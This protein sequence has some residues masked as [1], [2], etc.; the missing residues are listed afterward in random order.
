[1]P[2]NSQPVI[3]LVEPQLDENVGMCARAMLN[4]GLRRLRLVAPREGGFGERARATAADADAVLD[5]AEVFATVDAA[6]ADCHRVYATTVRERALD[7]PVTDAETAAAGI[8]EAGVEGRE[9]AI[10]FG[11]EASGLDN[12]AVSRADVLLTFPTN[13]E[14]P[15]LNLAQAVLLFGWEWRRA[16]R[17]IGDAVEPES[18]ATG[19]ATRGELEG[20]LQRVE[21]ELDD[22]GFFL[23]PDLK[24]HGRRTLRGLFSKSR[25]TGRELKFLHGMLSALVRRDA[26][27]PARGGGDERGRQ[28]RVGDSTGLAGESDSI[29]RTETRKKG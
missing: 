6:V 10:L 19:W 29:D 13:P 12:E 28:G 15:S 18:E 2:I 26:N 3:V 16:A 24:P 27:D 20:F 25:P 7:L 9:V 22:R 1:M 21:A 14:F 23:T 4:C 17:A 5:D 11:P 8:L